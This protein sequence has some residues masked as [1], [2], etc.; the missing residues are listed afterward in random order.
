MQSAMAGMRAAIAAAAVAGVALAATAEAAPIQVRDDPGFASVF[1]PN[2]SMNVEFQYWNGTSYVTQGA[3]AGTF[4]LQYRFT[5]GGGNPTGPITSFLT[6]CLEPDEF[7]DL[8][9]TWKNGDFRGSLASTSEYDGSLD[10]RVG[11]GVAGQEDLL[12]GVQ[13]RGEAAQ[14]RRRANRP[15]PPPE[16]R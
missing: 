15:A 1:G 5:D 7:L 10:R 4:A 8:N 12:S 11:Q 6:Y 13:A 3:L 9:G 2:G 16:D 14:Q